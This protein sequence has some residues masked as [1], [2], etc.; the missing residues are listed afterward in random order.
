MRI[1]RGNFVAQHFRWVALVIVVTALAIAWYV[2]E[3][4]YAERWPGGGSRVGI[5]LGL[6]AGVIFVFEAALPLRRTRWL[7][8]ARL[9]GNAKLWMKAHLWLGLL[10][11]PLVV[12][13]CGFR[14]GGTFTKIGRAHV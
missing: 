6:L 9:A 13:H 8:T 2:G 1:D 3:A 10:T 14:T 12:L 5:A 7:R 4:R 11:V